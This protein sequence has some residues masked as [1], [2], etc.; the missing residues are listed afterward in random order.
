MTER[1]LVTGGT[2]FVGSHLVRALLERGAEVRAFDIHE[3]DEHFPDAAEFVRG[4]V[5][6][7]D[8]VR[9]AAHGCSVIIAN[10]ALVPLSQAT[11]DE[12]LRVNRSGTEVTLGV[13]RQL[14]AYVAH[15]SSSAI[16]GQPARN[17]VPA[18]A[19]MSPFEP[20]GVSKAAAE[21]VVH[22]Y[23]VAGLRVSS[24]RPRTLVGPGRLGLF[25]VV[26]DRIRAGKSVPLFGSGNNRVQLAD[27]SDYA[28]A[29]MSAVERRASGDYN[30]GA[31]AFGTVREDIDALI[32]RVGSSSHTAPIPV[33]LL[34]AVLIPAAA[35][36]LSPLSKWHWVHASKDF[37]FDT[38]AAQR[39]L[40]WSPTRSNVDSLVSA[41]NEYLTK[42]PVDKGSAHRRPMPGLL[43][44]VLRT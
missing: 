31:S 1:V 20:Y 9:A 15:I 4:D 18:D 7:P 17:P 36:G 41:Y 38:T 10:A 14:G 11:P 42:P 19:P 13:A 25:E 26:F 39:D 24:L 44:R 28:A 43:A 30:I 35:L 23:R 3:P 40:G 33:P 21:D 32:K 22:A 8:V 2:G 12:F 37:Y 29:V 5:C 27:V 6:V 16:F 34:K